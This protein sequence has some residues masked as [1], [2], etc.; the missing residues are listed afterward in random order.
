MLFRTCTNCHYPIS[1]TWYNSAHCEQRYKVRRI[2]HI[3]QG[4]GDR[5]GFLIGNG[6]AG[7]VSLRP[8]DRAPETPLRQVKAQKLES[9]SSHSSKA[10]TLP[11]YP[12]PFARAVRATT[13]SLL[14]LL[15]GR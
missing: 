6:A 15:R 2:A 1:P 7:C 8:G 14:L 13:D 4:N 9:I 11:F 5:R 10:V 12:L 3:T